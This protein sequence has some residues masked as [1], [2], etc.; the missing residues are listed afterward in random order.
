MQH[1]LS[2]LILTVILAFPLNSFA[3]GKRLPVVKQHGMVVCAEPQAADIG[4]EVLK[5]GGNAVDA[6]VATAFALAVTYPSAGN[7]GGGGFLILHTAN[8]QNIAIDG[9][10]T[11]PALMDSTYY[12][13]QPDGTARNSLLGYTAAGTPGTVAMLV[14]THQAFG[15]LPLAEL[16]QPAIALADSGFIVSHPFAASLRYYA[17]QFARFPGS[18]AIFLKETPPDSLLLPSPVDGQ[19]LFITE[20]RYFYHAGDRFYQKDLAQTLRKIAE[21]GRDG[22]YT[23][24][25][26]QRIE[27][28]M[29]AHGGAMRAADFANYQV[30]FREPVYGSYRGYEVVSMPPP[31]SGGIALVQLL[32][33]LEGY[34]LAWLGHNSA[35]TIHLMTEA[36]RRVYADRFEYLGDPDYVD[37]PMEGLTSKLYADKLRQKINRYYKTPSRAVK[38]GNPPGYESPET[39]HLCVVDSAGNAVSLTYTLNTSYGSK[40]VVPGTG[41]LLNNELDDFTTQPG[42]PNYYGLMQG[43]RNIVAPGKRPLSSMTPTILL[44]NGTVAMVVGSPGGSTIITTVLQI[45]LNVIDHG[46]NA[47]EALHAP[48]V[49]HQ[50]Y[51]DKIY[52]EKYGLAHDVIQNLSAKGHRVDEHYWGYIGR[53]ELILIDPETGELQGM[54]DPRGQGAV[55]GY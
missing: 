5:R 52:Y 7:L 9:R 51:P 13:P 28:A 30:K 39:T 46:M 23:G 34:P 48:R 20:D 19:P 42:Q 37:V 33:I 24:E 11:A 55:R 35:E 45:I 1:R 38:A 29:I 3:Y 6:A 16:L 40:V 17:P 47:H 26:P 41:F 8:G 10:E 54:S 22:F 4:A 12:L 18:A 25:I 53:A 27:Q 14:E 2:I 32:N 21:Y 49:H 15:T 44:K 43:N 31:S 36:E 50:W